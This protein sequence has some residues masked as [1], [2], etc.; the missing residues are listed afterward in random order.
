MHVGAAAA[1]DDVVAWPGRSGPAG[2]LGR[3]VV[4]LEVV[5]VTADRGDI[6][7][8]RVVDE[9]PDRLAGPAALPLTDPAGMQRGV[10]QQRLAGDQDLGLAIS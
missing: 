7:V 1:A 5:H 4:V 8:V 3:A 6:A 2:R 10:D 9:F